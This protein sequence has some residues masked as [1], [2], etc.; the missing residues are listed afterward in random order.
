MQYVLD[1]P[2]LTESHLLVLIRVPTNSYFFIF[3]G[4]KIKLTAVYNPQPSFP[5]AT[6]PC[7]L[8]LFPATL[9]PLCVDCCGSLGPSA[10]IS[11]HAFLSW[12]VIFFL[13]GL[14]WFVFCIPLVR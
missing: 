3:L 10:E 8:F 1:K 2:D 4:N 6:P 5:L 7:I 12:F 11:V 13:F 14:V 9:Q